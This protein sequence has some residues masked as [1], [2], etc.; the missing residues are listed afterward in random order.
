MRRHTARAEGER[1][2]VDNRLSAARGTAVFTHYRHTELEKNGRVGTLFELDQAA[3]DVLLRHDSIGAIALGALGFRAQYRD[4]RTGGSLRTPPTYDYNLAG[5][6]V[7][8]IGRRALRLQVGG[9]YDFTKYVPR[10]GASIDVGGQR[11]AVR[12]RTFN[13]V[14]GALGMLYAARQDVRF[15]TSISRAYRTPDFNELYS[16]GPHLAANAF[17]V[18]DPNLRAETGIGV[19]AFARVT[20]ERLRFE[21]AA[22]RNWLADYIASSSRGQA[23]QSGQGAPLFQFTNEDAV[24]TG[25]EAAVEVGV[26]SRWAAEGTVSYVEARFTNDRAPIPVFTLTPTGIDTTFQPASRYPALI[27][28]LNGRVELRYERPR[29]FGGGGVRFAARQSR[30]GDFEEPTGG[31]AIAHVTTGY[32]FL[33]RSQLHT[34]T[35]GVDNLFD[36]EYR[37]HLSRAKAIMPEPGRNVRLLYRLTF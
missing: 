11:V 15:G 36:T 16:N 27:P 9:R 13:A 33:T 17:E 6:L 10:E 25:G 12:S 22:F 31:Y 32:R 26:T 18:G 14:S 29:A 21:L 2:F 28:P 30:T 3:G 4:I 5:F 8:E 24:F 34:L 37:N 20:R 23:I 19:D 1:H 35:L 7:E